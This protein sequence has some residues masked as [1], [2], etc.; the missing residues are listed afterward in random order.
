[1]LE[2]LAT[3]TW[4]AVIGTMW[5]TRTSYCAVL[6]V[7]FISHDVFVIVGISAST[8]KRFS[9]RTSSTYTRRCWILRDTWRQLLENDLDHSRGGCI[10]VSLHLA[11]PETY[12]RHSTSG[13]RKNSTLC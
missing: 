1:M 8:C 9:A 2:F 13:G 4:M 11:S 5:T 3:A 6:N 12:W 10:S 7:G